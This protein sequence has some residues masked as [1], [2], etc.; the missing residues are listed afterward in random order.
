M[1]VVFRHL[2]L[3]SPLPPP[4]SPSR[5][6]SSRSS[7]ARFAAAAASS[8]SS[9]RSPSP[10]S[11]MEA[12]DK[13]MEFPHV[14]A[15]HRSL[16][17]DLVSAVEERL[18]SQLL[19]CALPHDVRYYQS[20]AGSA[21]GSLYVRRGQGPSKVDFLLGSW[22]NCQLPTGGS[23]N[24]TSLSVYLNNSTD[25]PNFLFEL[26]RSSPTSLVLILD[27]PPRKDLVTDP[28]YL[29]T[30]YEDTQLESRR[31]VLDKLPEAQPYFSSALYIRCVV[32]PTAIML[33]IES[34]AGKAE[35]L[36]EIVENHVSPVAKEVLGIW[37]DKCAA[38]DRNVEE[39]E[40]AY[41][42]RRDGIIKRKTIE[43][44]LGSSFPRLF[45]PEIAKRVLD[46]LREVYGV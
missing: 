33:R 1:A 4:P 35:R 28:D 19:P 31:Q 6:P 44:D 46:V 37:L 26:I 45:G 9:S 40:R 34:G 24:I 15:P 17:I 22:L 10:A 12:A 18:G 8:S 21:R 5:S 16:M 2:S 14:S 38:V 43:I 23:L 27:L 30:F 3:L 36:D 11:P 7:S 13:F 20:D 29:S 32:S 25:A 39:E 41:L 42:G